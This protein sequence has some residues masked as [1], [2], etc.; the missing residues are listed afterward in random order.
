MKPP[1]SDGTCVYSPDLPDGRIRLDSP[2]WFAWLSSA[3]TTRFS[4]PLHDRRCG[5]ISGFMTVRHEGR[6]RGG[7]YGSVYRRQGA[8]LRR[9][10]LGPPSAV[11]HAR[12]EEV[13]AT[14]LRERDALA[15][16]DAPRSPDTV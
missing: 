7:H 1:T 15:R 3:S 16:R 14:L 12:L 5:Y 10:Y 8:R 6:Q 9:I 11:T 2:A 13:V 4:Y